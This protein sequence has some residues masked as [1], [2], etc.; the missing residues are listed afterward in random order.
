M[1]KGSSF[2]REVSK[3]LSFYVYIYKHPIAKIPFYVGKGKGETK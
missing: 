2:E 1:A 3:A